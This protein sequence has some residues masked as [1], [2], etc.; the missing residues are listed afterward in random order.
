MTAESG[1]FAINV[2]L[3]A[4]GD[5]F[6]SIDPSPLVERD[7]DDEIEDFVVDWARDAAHGARIRLVIREQTGEPFDADGIRASVANYFTYLRNRQD[8]RIRHL[9]REGRRAL[10]V[11]VLFLLVCSALGQALS[12]LIGGPVGATLK[13]GLL[14]I[15]WVANWRPVEIFLYDWRPM[16]GQLEIYERLAAARIE[17][18]TGH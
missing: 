4:I 11:G 14:I 2:K 12:A 1:E 17:F 15:G 18:I 9:L 5:L 16:H 10:G 7:I 3:H 8:R 6:K 13:E